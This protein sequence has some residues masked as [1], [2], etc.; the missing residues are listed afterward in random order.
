MN[1]KGYYEKKVRKLSKEINA[2]SRS[3]SKT[4]KYKLE[5]L[6]AKRDKLM[7]KYKSLK[8][9]VLVQY[10][11]KEQWF[12][13]EEEAKVLTD[14]LDKEE[15]KYKVSKKE[16]TDFDTGKLE[17]DNPNR[18]V[19]DKQVSSDLLV[20][21]VKE[22]YE[23]EQSRFV[24]LMNPKSKTWK[25]IDRKKGI[26]VAESKKK[27]KGVPVVTKMS[28][29]KYEKQSRMLDEFNIEIMKQ[30]FG[31]AAKINYNG[32]VVTFG[33]LPNETYKVVKFVISKLRPEERKRFYADDTGTW[34]IVSK[35]DGTLIVTDDEGND[36]TKILKKRIKQAKL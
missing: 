35:A 36:Y 28:E 27:F 13:T 32:K 5:M 26:I 11:D 14:K 3:P 25:K 29:S 8:E 1:E 12:E 17:I 31:S 15:I 21:V 18:E 23:S 34:D 9:A 20:G 16:R 22:A 7:K 4:D 30:S 10:K 19:S 24:Q 2:L 6:K 33:E